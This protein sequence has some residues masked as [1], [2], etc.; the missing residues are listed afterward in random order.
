M[1]VIKTKST[2]AVAIRTAA[3]GL[4]IISA[5][6]SWAM[7]QEYCV[8]CAQP[9]ALYRCIIEGARPGGAV[10]LQALCVTA[11]AK[12]GQHGTCT[13]QRGVGVIDCNGAIKRVAIPLDGSAPVVAAPAA[14]PA[15]AP[16]SGEPK[17]VAEMLQRTKEQTDRDWERNNAAIKAN[18]EKA[19]AFFKKSW[20]CLASF[21]FKCGG[22]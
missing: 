7:A 8:S 9:D 18:N 22:S 20:D 3:T 16:T 21:F 6:G 17:T 14:D 4:L 12:E 13:V 11:L 10:S 1:G 19:G 2:S 15:P 5:A